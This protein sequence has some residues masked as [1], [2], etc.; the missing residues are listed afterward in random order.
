MSALPEVTYT[1]RI[2]D[3][4]NGNVIAV[5]DQFKFL[6]ISRQVNKPG[7]YQLVFDGQRTPDIVDL[8]GLDYRLEFWRSG[9]LIGSPIREY[10]AMNRTYVRAQFRSGIIQHSMFGRGLEDLLQRRII[11]SYADVIADLSGPIVCGGVYNAEVDL[12]MWACASLHAGSNATVANSRLAEGVTPGLIMTVPGVSAGGAGIWEGDTAYRNLLEVLQELSDWSWEN[13]T[14]GFDFS[15]QPNGYSGAEFFVHTGGLGVDRS[16]G[17]GVN[18]EVL[19]TAEQG[20]LKDI[21]FSRARSEEINRIYALGDGDAAARDIEVVQ[22][23]NTTPVGLGGLGTD[24]SSWNLIEAARSAPSNTAGAQLR[25]YGENELAKNSAPSTAVFVPRNQ[26]GAVYGVDYELGDTVTV[27]HEGERVDIRITGV[28]IFVTGD[29]DENI[30]LTTE[31][32]RDKILPSYFSFDDS[33]AADFIS[34]TATKS[35]T[36]LN[37]KAIEDL[38]SRLDTQLTR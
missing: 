23:L 22:D 18:R 16:L 3:T 4:E 36:E 20:N 19:F 28:E 15:V 8:T 9:R 32:S 38:K 30:Q 7:Y 24:S 5:L 25:S 27:I 31:V 33:S 17:N 29:G 6:Q 2:V 34:N 11:A 26:L 37:R 21:W 35:E 12:V 13:G 10:V 14:T 1:I